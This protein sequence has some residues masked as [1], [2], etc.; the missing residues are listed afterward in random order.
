[1]NSGRV[2]AV[3]G[4][5]LDVYTNMAFLLLD[6]HIQPFDE[7]APCLYAPLEQLFYIGCI[8]WASFG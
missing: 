1:M 2:I 7:R 4:S 8:K 5:F 6:E 3:Y